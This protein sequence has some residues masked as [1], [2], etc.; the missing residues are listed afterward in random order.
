M[1][2]IIIMV[3]IG[4]ANFLT[5]WGNSILLAQS[6]RRYEKLFNPVFLR[7]LGSFGFLIAADGIFLYD[8]VSTY[9][10]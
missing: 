6:N 5:L 8:L 7:T 9:W 1:T 4:L 2:T 10:K 3:L